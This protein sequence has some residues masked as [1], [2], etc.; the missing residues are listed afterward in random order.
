MLPA[1]EGI[2]RKSRSFF[3]VFE[4][5]LDGDGAISLTEMQAEAQVP[6]LAD[7]LVEFKESK[8]E[9]LRKISFLN[10]RLRHEA[11][12]LLDGGQSPSHS[13]GCL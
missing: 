2:S 9:W 11:D 4:N 1:L 6:I 13:A 5:D 7:T 10:M 3:F 8:A 12:E